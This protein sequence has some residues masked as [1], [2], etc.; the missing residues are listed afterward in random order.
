MVYPRFAMDQIHRNRIF[1]LFIEKHPRMAWIYVSTKVD[2]YQQQ[3]KSGE[4]L[5]K[6]GWVRLRGRERHGWRDRAYM[7]VF[8]ASP[9]IGPTPPSQGMHAVAVAVAVAVA[10]AGAGRSPAGNTPPTKVGRP[11]RQRRTMLEAMTLSGRA[12]S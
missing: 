1:R 12:A 7:D 6:A 11:T 9:A 4:S 8:T 2:S 10:S 5:S 3:P